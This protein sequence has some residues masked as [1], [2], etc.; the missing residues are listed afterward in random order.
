MPLLHFFNPDT[1][2]SLASDR[3]YYTPPARITR[4][5]RDLCLLPSLYANRGDLI[6][7]EDIPAPVLKAL[8]Y[9]S[10]TSKRDIE[11]ITLSEL[12][13]NPEL[14]IHYRA[15]P[16]GW[17]R[18]VRQ[19]F[20][21]INKHASGVPSESD[22][23]KLRELSHRRTTIGFMAMIPEK[24]RCGIE[25][26]VEVKDPELAVTAFRQDARRFFKAP[27]SSSGRGI[28]LTD[29]LEERHVEPW[30]RGI[31]NKQGSVMMEKAYPR[32]LDFATEWVCREGKSDFLGVSVFDTSRRG[33]YHGN[34]PGSQEELWSKIELEIKPNLSE[35]IDA[36]REALQSIISPFYEGPLGVDMLATNDGEVNPCV[37]INLRHTMGM[38][39]L[40]GEYRA[41]KVENYK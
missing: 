16:W 19:L 39:G 7:I 2:Y 31:I 36:Q 15:T 34:H 41:A 27:W 28:L 24:L 21:D 3:R 37:E 23:E 6:L 9:F 26:P 4:L 22:I 13:E 29:D 17:N 32:K 38:T 20:L 10:E 40:I 14:L 5:R 12:K 1:D 35:I 8:P 25:L 33:K 30:V 18:S 11:F